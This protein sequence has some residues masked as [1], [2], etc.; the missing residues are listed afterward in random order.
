VLLNTHHKVISMIHKDANRI[1]SQ[2]KL[3]KTQEN[4]VVVAKVA[5]V[6]AVVVAKEAVAADAP[7]LAGPR[8]CEVID[9]STGVI[10]E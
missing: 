8:P 2:P 6:K 5:A 10:G 7:I 3:L 9:G 4:Y 1:Y